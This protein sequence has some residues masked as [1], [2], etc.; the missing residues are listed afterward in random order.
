MNGSL[1]P[2]PPQQTLHGRIREDLRERIVRGVL[3]P[4]DRVPSESELMAQYGVS[5]ITVRQA[6]GDLQSA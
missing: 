5:R 6:L 1:H 4:N 2:P 3:Q